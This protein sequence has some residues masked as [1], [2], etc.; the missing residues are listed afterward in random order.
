MNFRN[1]IAD[2]DFYLKVFRV[3]FP[4]ALSHLLLSCRSI[5]S[6]IMVS[7]IG[8]V[9][10]I[11]NASNIIYLHDYL[12]WGIEA[13]AA[14]FFGAKQYR[15][16]ART[17]GIFLIMALLNAVFWIFAVYL[18][19]DKLLLFY[20]DDPEIAFYSLQYLRY[21]VISLLFMC[22]TISFKCMYQSMHMTRLTFIESAIYVCLNI[23]NNCLF[24]FV[25]DLGIKGAGLSLL[26]TEMI[27][28]FG[29]FIYTLKKETGFSKRLQ[30]NVC[31]RSQFCPT[32]YFQG[33]ADNLQRDPLRLRTVFVQ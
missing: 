2:K 5:I 13:G 31:H 10:A 29:M 25:F 9:T 27:C 19:G 4:I 28:C 18:F 22:V 32:F 26:A 33:P 15:N 7:S 30:G 1:Y 8:M 20:L 17:Q 16:M 3:A 12:L 23:I 21:A 24:I 14:Q 11:G 6:S